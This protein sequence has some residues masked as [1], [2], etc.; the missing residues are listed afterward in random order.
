VIA[1]FVKP[2]AIIQNTS[3]TRLESPDA[4]STVSVF[5]TAGY[6][7]SFTYNFTKLPAKSEDLT[8]AFTRV[9]ERV[10]LDL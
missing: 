2:F 5:P 8:G 1:V 9:I 10:E 7:F 3:N 6:F 4:I